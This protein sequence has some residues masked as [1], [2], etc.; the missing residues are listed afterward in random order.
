M[1]FSRRMGTSKGNNCG[2]VFFSVL[3]GL[4]VSR[5]GVGGMVKSEGI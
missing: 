4:A 5:A 3:S 1:I 2:S